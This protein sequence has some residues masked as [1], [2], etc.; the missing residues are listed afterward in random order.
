MKIQLRDYFSIRPEWEE[1]KRILHIGVPSGIENGMFQF[2]KITLFGTAYF[3][4]G[5]AYFALG[6]AYFAL[7]TVYFAG[8]TAHFA[9]G[10]TF[11][12]ITLGIT[13]G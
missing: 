1:I 6:I 5:T 13:W 10:N 4:V 7:G 8:G 3:A 2:G 12:G 11:L 9:G